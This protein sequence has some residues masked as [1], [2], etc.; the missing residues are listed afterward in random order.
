MATI[1]FTWLTVGLAAGGSL[2]FLFG[3]IAARY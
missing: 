3:L 1:V 2:G